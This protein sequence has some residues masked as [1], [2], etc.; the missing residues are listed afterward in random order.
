MSFW[1][2]YDDGGLGDDTGDDTGAN[3]RGRLEGCIVGDDRLGDDTGANDCGRLEGCIVGDENDSE[4]W[5][6]SIVGDIVSSR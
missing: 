6:G 3:D 5:V 2:K 1:R 4:N